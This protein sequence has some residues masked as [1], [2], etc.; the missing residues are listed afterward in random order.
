MRPC[1]SRCQCQ[2]GQFLRQGQA[3]DPG[4]RPRKGIAQSPLA[5]TASLQAYC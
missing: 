4:P 2:P 5:K 3:E 1:S